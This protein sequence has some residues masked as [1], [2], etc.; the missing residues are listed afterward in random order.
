MPDP[1]EVLV[2]VDSLKFCECLTERMYARRVLLAFLCAVAL[3][4]VMILVKQHSQ[5]KR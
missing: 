4:M 5:S 2:V 1:Q 3:T